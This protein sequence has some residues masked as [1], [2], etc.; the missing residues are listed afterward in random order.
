MGICVIAIGIIFIWY[1]RKT[2][3]TSSTVGNLIKLV[4]SLN[5]KIP[6]LNSLLPILSELTSSQ[7][8]DDAITSVTVTHLSQTP[9]DGLFLPPVMDPKL[10]METEKPSTTVN[11]PF[12]LE[13][14]PLNTTVVKTGPLSLEM[15]NHATTD[16]NDKGIINLKKYSRYL[17]KK[18]KPI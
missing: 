4:P 18:S 2:S 3:L 6:T 15:F 17:N 16:L 8:I 14:S 1:K 9:L 10:Q 12:L 11:I 7:N 5:G 13:P